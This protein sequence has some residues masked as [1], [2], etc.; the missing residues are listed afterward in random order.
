M[1]QI[2]S[3]TPLLLPP[4]SLVLVTGVNGLIASHAA[5]QLLAYGYSIRGTVR[6][7]S[8]NSYLQKLFDT[9][10]GPSKCELVEIP[11]VS[12]PKAW[13]NAIKGVAAV[14]HVVGS[15]DFQV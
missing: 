12:A 4:G 10:H 15:V 13:E 8:R 6:S 3:T 11:D 14:A 7:V 2:P 9:R 1:A 5:D